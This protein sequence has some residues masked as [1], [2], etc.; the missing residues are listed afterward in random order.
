MSL[1]IAKL[2]ILISETDTHVS[3][4]HGF[5]LK[6]TKNEIMHA[7]AYGFYGFYRTC[8]IISLPS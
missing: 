4:E 5:V 8:C 7:N 3:N 1:V 2:S 6:Q